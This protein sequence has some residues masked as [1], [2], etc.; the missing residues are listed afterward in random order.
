M[1]TSLVAGIA[2]ALAIGPM[3]RADGFDPGAFQQA[4]DNVS[5][6]RIKEAQART[7][8]QDGV[9]VYKLLLAINTQYFIKDA[10]GRRNP[11]AGA[12]A[13]AAA[14][15]NISPELLARTVTLLTE[16]NGVPGDN[17]RT[18][19]EPTQE[20]TLRALFVLGAGARAFIQPSGKFNGRAFLSAANALDKA[21]LAKANAVFGSEATY[22]LFL[23]LHVGAQTADAEGTFIPA[24]LQKALVGIPP[25]TLEGKNDS[26]LIDAVVSRLK[27]K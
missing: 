26:A 17:P 1:K 20:P 21:T 8:N 2:V 7:D 24:A 12:T 5:N 6:E 9:V 11:K 10:A 15:T 16:T 4:C 13:F 27:T 14:L 23:L 19:S 3:V 25:D 22:S 18:L